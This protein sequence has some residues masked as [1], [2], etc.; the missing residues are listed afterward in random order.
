M[1][2]SALGD[3]RDVVNWLRQ[4][5][6]RVGN[7]YT[8][9][10]TSCVDDASFS[11]FLAGLAQDEKTHAEYMAAAA[12]H[13]RHLQD[14]PALDIVL[15]EQTRREVEGL[16]ERFERLLDQSRVTQRDLLEYV[17]RVE[18]SEWNRIFLYVSDEY[19][20]TGR[21]GERV[22]REV[23]AHLLRIQDFIDEL[24]RELR[25]SIDVSTLPFVGEV[26]FLVVNDHE[27]LR[28]LLASLLS[29]R[30]AVDTAAEGREALNKLR[31]HFHDVIVCDIRMPGMDGLE[32][33]RRAVQYDSHLQ[34]H[35]LFCGADVAPE[36]E[37]YLKENNLRLLRKPFGLSEFY[38][39]V[40]QIL[41]AP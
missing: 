38:E 26:R 11:G 31:D 12:E 35:F 5:E 25:P 30:G 7:L 6:E 17:A 28:R 39:A 20:K 23:Q 33:Y 13:L 15:D 27:P 32:F 34:R 41:R 36:T 21:E 37:D 40:D 14:R 4:V 18:A 10:A 24:P 19:H 1:G 8:K 3:I 29:R 9:A 22:T 16:L 2:T